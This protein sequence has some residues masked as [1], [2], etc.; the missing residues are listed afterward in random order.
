MFVGETEVIWQVTRKVIIQMYDESVQPGP[1]G[2]VTLGVHTAH[3]FRPFLFNL[4]SFCYIDLN[5]SSFF[6]F[7][8]ASFSLFH[9]PLVFI[10]F[11]P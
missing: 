1:L 2:T 8:A 5:R 3:D 10:Y 7:P 6:H 4:S 9:V 11:D